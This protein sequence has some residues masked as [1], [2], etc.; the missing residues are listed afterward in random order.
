MDMQIH[1]SKVYQTKEFT[2]VSWYQDRPAL[3]L[4]LIQRTEINSDEGIIDVGAGAST[5]VDHLCATG[6]QNL[7]V[8]DISEESLKIARERLAEQYDAAIEWIV[9]DVTQVELPQNGYSLWHDRAV[10]HFLTDP[11]I[12]DRYVA[13]VR[14]ALRPG[15]YVIMATF[16]PDGPAQCSGLDVARYDAISMHKVFGDSFELVDS[17]NESHKT[18]WEAEQRFVYCYCRKS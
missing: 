12:R 3:S 7:T 8:L 1:W 17:I 15:G 4:D 18:P 6:Y 16:A 13:Q 9:G 11:I 14:H 5:L 10:F 2:D